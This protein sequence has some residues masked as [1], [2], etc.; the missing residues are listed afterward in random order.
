MYCSICGFKNSKFDVKCKSCGAYLQN[1][2]YVLNL[3]DILSLLIFN[4][5][6]GFHKIII[7]KRKNFSIF[8][9]S[10]SGIAITFEIFR[11][12]RVGEKY[13]NLVFLFLNTLYFG[14]PLG[15]LFV[16]TMAII[17]KIFLYRFKGVGL[18]AYFAIVAYSMFP[19]ALSTFFLL[20]SILAVFGIYY[21]TETP[22]ANELKPLAFYIFSV[23]NWLLKVYSFFL[24]ISGLK[25]ITESFWKGLVFAILTSI[26]S[27]VLLNL[28]TEAIKIVL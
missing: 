7:S 4:P 27:F 19:I 25:H 24:L 16:L 2:V 9:S 23:T 20:P 14:V 28:L 21:F 1:P 15:I 12:A 3:F 18:R 11:Y 13:E 6:E 5:D 17:L 10:L 26:C 22:K 8:L